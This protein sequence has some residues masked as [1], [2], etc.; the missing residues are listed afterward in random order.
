MRLGT[1]ISVA[2][3]MFVLDLLKDC[4]GFANMAKTRP[5]MLSER[6]FPVQAH[7]SQWPGAHRHRAACPG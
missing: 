3:E 2:P 4:F 1:A 7:L 6:R 5:V